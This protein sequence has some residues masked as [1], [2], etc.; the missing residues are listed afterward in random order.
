MGSVGKTSGLFVVV[1]GI[2]LVVGL[3]VVVT[4]IDGEG[5]FSVEGASYLLVV[6]V[7]VVGGW[8]DVVV[9]VVGTVGLYGALVVVVV[10]IV[11][12]NLVV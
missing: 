1:V 2:V 3:A 8:V 7:V 9:V 6:V 11:G 4:K 10:G 12:V 5:I